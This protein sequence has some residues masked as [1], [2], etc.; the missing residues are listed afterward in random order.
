MV[1]TAALVESSEALASLVAIGL[2]DTALIPRAVAGCSHDVRITV[3]RLEIT[4]W[5]LTALA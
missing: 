3:L 5:N 4:R 1:L 2:Q